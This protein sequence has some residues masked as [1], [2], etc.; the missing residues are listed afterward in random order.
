M[1][2]TTVSLSFLSE[3]EDLLKEIFN[4]YLM[5]ALMSVFDYLWNLVYGM[6][7]RWFSHLLFSVFTTFLKVIYIL[8]RIFDVFSCTVGVYV[9]NDAGQMVATSGYEDVSQNASLLDV[10]MQSDPVVNAVLGMT[11]GAFALCFLITIFAVIRSMG[12]GLREMNRPVSHV[13]K[14][15]VKACVTFALIPLGCIFVVKMA[16]ITI[17][18]VQYYM[19]SNID[20]TRNRSRFEVVSEALSN[21]TGKPRRGTKQSQIEKAIAAAKIATPNAET[22]A[23]DLIYYL[24]VK[25]A[26]RNPGNGAYYMSGQHFQNTLVAENDVDVTKINWVYAFFELFLVLVIFL[27]LIIECMVRIFMLLILFVVSPYFVAMMPLDDG[28]KFKRWKEMFVGFTISI[29]GPI[30]MMR[31]YLV[32]L[33]YIVSGDTLDMGFSPT[34]TFI[35]RLFFI[36]AGAFSVYKS[37]QLL[38]DIINPEVSRFLSIA[39]SPVD[40]GV[41]AAVGAASAGLSTGLSLAKQGLKGQSAG[42]QSG[43]K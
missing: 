26:L 32:L 31:L 14:Q 15:T 8:E 39:S 37:Q 10:L 40:R 35:F 28:A 33:P 9:R 11:L 29:F 30:V 17:S 34:K 3:L 42:G 19:P 16:G 6:F 4:E 41:R 25:D 18:S 5:P 24:S 22:R 27:K 43:G 20:G 13:L 12:E 23:C 1:D 38:L 7:F 2:M 21:N 36:A